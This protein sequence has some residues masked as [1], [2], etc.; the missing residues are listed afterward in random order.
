MFIFKIF[1]NNRPYL[2]TPDKKIIVNHVL[3]EKEEEVNKKNKKRKRNTEHKAKNKYK[4]KTKNETLSDDESEIDWINNT[5]LDKI[6]F[7]AL[8]SW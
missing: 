7:K 2:S 8:R 3:R 4:K 5:Y 1:K 6:Y